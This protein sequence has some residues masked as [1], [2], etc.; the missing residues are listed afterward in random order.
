MVTAI[1]S[2]LATRHSSSLETPPDANVTD[3]L[4]LVELQQAGRLQNQTVELPEAVTELQG[5]EGENSPNQEELK[6]PGVTGGQVEVEEVTE[7]G[8]EVQFE[9]EEQQMLDD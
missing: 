6:K 9:P 8:N 2:G 4:D 1:I 7:G 5:E 3:G